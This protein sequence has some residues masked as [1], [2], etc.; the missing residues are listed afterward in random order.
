MA[1]FGAGST[2]GRVNIGIGA[3]GPSATMEN[4][5][6]T[7]N[8]MRRAASSPAPRHGMT[9]RPRGPRPDTM[10]HRQGRRKAGK[11][12]LQGRHQVERLRPLVRHQAEKQ[13][14]L[15][16]HQ[17]EKQRLLVRRQAAKRRLPGL[18]RRHNEK[19]L[20]KKS[21]PNPAIRR[22]LRTL[23]ARP[24]NRA[25]TTRKTTINNAA[26]RAVEPRWP[27]VADGQCFVDRQSIRADLE[28]EYR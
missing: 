1:S 28:A 19:A 21:R 10:L 16:Q 20:M 17:A 27:S 25:K 3:S 26:L 15:V 7:G 18:L 4:F 12:C 22:R 13:R 8:I 6:L 14:P 9:L 11:L 23:A 2:G 5:V 24:R